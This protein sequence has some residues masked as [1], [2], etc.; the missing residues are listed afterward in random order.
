MAKWEF[1]TRSLNDK[2]D[3]YQKWAETTT[4][5]PKDMGLAYTAL[6]LANEAGEYLG[7]LKKFI[8]DGELDDIAAAHELG[9]VLW[10]VAMAASELGY[11]LSEIVLMNI[12]KLNDRKDRG[13]LSGSGDTR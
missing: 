2:W 8:R 11:D 3:E 13:V 9:D 10:Y 1:A 6:G 5:Y 4:I 7:K 12:E